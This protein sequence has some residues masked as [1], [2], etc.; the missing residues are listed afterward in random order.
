[1]IAVI[2]VILSIVTNMCTKFVPTNVI[3]KQYKLLYVNDI[4]AVVKQL[5]Y[6]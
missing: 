1:M 3:L 6:G 4:C 5:K 2:N